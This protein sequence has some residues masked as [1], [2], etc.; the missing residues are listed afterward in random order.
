MR[1]YF[2]T[3]HNAKIIA[4][5]VAVFIMAGAANFIYQKS[6]YRFFHNAIQSDSISMEEKRKA[7]VERSRADAALKTY[8]LTTLVGLFSESLADNIGE[9]LTGTSAKRGA[10]YA[11]QYERELKTIRRLEQEQRAMGKTFAER[12]RELEENL[13]ELEERRRR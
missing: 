12:S 8:G 5:L 4:V 3:H 9:Q 1:E 6:R 7:F 11:E 13:Q 10:V 2:R